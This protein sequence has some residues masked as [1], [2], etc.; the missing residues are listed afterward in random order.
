MK[1][2]HGTLLQWCRLDEWAGLS[3]ILRDEISSFGPRPER[4]MGEIVLASQIRRYHEC[5]MVRAGL[6][7]WVQIGDPYG[8][9]FD[10]TRSKMSYTMNDARNIPI[11]FNL[12]ILLE[13]LRLMLRLSGVR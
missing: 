13:T 5:H 4:M 1:S 3:N 11:L 9:T 12:V 10:N 6:M 7:G 8:A 2:L